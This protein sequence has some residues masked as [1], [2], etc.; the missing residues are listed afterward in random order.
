MYMTHIHCAKLPV[1]VHKQYKN[2]RKK[3]KVLNIAACVSLNLKDKKPH[4]R[5]LIGSSH[6]YV[7][8][9]CYVMHQV[10]LQTRVQSSL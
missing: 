10:A 1:P 9:V 7:C 4:I 2:Y 6:D 5:L 3:G 8:Y